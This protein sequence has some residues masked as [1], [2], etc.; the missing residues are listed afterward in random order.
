MPN[1]NKPPVNP[2][3]GVKDQVLFYWKGEYYRGRVVAS[4][5]KGNRNVYS[6]QFYT[7]VVDKFC[8]VNLS[9]PENLLMSG[10]YFAYLPLD[11]KF[12]LFE[13]VKTGMNR[14]GRIVARGYNPVADENMYMVRFPF[15]NKSRNIPVR[16]TSLHLNY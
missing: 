12:L 1:H 3:F 4:C 6:V 11:S 7:W 8:L 9:I 13:P 5:R 2:E 16:E 14:E 10:D 15:G